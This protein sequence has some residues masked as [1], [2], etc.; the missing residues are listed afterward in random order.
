[1]TE[2]PST[3]LEHQIERIHKLL[4]NNPSDVTWN[5]K[6]P[7]PDNPNQLRQIDITIKRNGESIHVECRI[8]KNPQDVTWIEEL[9]GRRLSLHADAIIAVSSSGFTEG[10][11]RKATKFNIHL[12]TLEKLTD[13]EITLW[14]TMARPMLIFYEFIGSHVTFTMAEHCPVTP[15][16][17]TAEDNTP[18]VWRGPFELVMKTFDDDP[19]LDNISKTFDV[20]LFAPLLV[21]G[22]KP[23][24]I[25]LHSTARR[26]SCPM[27]LDAALRYAASDATIDAPLAQVQTHQ[28]GLVEIIHSADEVALISDTSTLSVPHSCFFHSIWM[29][30]GRSVNFKWLKLVNAHMA[31][32]SDVSITFVLRHPPP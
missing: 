9:I 28:N 32:Q 23:V 10:A 17:V 13:Y 4:E 6:I 24:K 11:V 3:T 31:T 2:N 21:N 8:H 30:F 7:D 16:A 29:D 27:P 18:I 1:M 22:V 5:D 14:G 25:E 20:E 12:R 26:L 19:D 15:I